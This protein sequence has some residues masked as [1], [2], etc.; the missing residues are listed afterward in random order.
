M[1]LKLKT[2]FSERSTV[3]N[4]GEKRTEQRE[5]WMEQWNYIPENIYQVHIYIYEYYLN[6]NLSKGQIG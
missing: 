2:M 1:A 3:K 5:R 4:K 6:L